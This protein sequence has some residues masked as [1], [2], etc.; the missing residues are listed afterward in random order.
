MRRVN[1]GKVAQ[2]ITGGVGKAVAADRSRQRDRDVGKSRQ[3]LA[4]E[5]D[6]RIVQHAVADVDI[7][8]HADFI[9]PRTAVR[10]DAANDQAADRKIGIGWEGIRVGMIARIENRQSEFGQRF[11][12]TEIYRDFVEKFLNTRRDRR[13]ECV[14]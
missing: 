1:G 10:T 8:H 9:S 3:H 4:G 11:A 5:D 13:D 7:R 6:A 2:H 12:V 14:F